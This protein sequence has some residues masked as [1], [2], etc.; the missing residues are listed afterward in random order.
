[1]RLYIISYD[2]QAKVSATGLVVKKRERSISYVGFAVSLGIEN[3]IYSI[4]HMI[5][6]ILSTMCIIWAAQSVQLPFQ[7]SKLKG[8]PE[9]QEFT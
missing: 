4:I 2:K 8:N 6:I 1:M 7:A 9:R 5:V 3:V